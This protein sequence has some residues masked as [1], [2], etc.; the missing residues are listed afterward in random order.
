MPDETN[1]PANAKYYHRLNQS[2]EILCVLVLVAGMGLLLYGMKAGETLEIVLGLVALLLA[3][4]LFF[5]A[6]KCAM[7]ADF[8]NQALRR[9]SLYLISKHR[10]A[11]LR[12]VKAPVD[13]I[14]FLETIEADQPVNYD[15]LTSRLDYGL[16]SERAAEVRA[17]VLKYTRFGPPEPAT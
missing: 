11:T 10:L 7:K 17:Q 16:G 8:E 2:S 3:S 6:V 5:A 12:A 1:Q 15:E 13:V 14:K 9:E 4:V